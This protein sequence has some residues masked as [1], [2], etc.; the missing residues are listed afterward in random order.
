MLLDNVILN[1]ITL[2]AANKPITLSVIMLSV[3]MLRVIVLTVV[4][5]YRQGIKTFFTF[6]LTV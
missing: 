2:S 4:S 5:P 1:I 6:S 3:I